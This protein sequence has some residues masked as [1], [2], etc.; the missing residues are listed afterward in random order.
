[1][2][3]KT[4]GQ[5]FTPDWIVNE[6]LN[7]LNYQKDNI[8][9]KKII[10]PACGDGAFLK[11][12]V[13]RIIDYF[14]SKNCSISEIK[15]YIENNVYGIEI[16]EVEFK[17]C[18]TNLNNL[19]KK[20]LNIDLNIDWKIYR[21]NTLLKYKDFLGLFDYV[22]GNPPYI[23]IHS[24]DIETRNLLKKDFVFSEGT[25]DI[26]VSF[27]ELGFKLLNKNG[28]LGYITPNSY[29][30]NSSYKQFRKY[31]KDNKII[32]SITDFKANK[33]FKNFSTYTAITIINFYDK[34]KSFIYKELK[35]DKIQEV[36]EIDY[37]E[38]NDND[39]SFSI[40]EDMIFLK[41][42]YSSTN[43][44]VS[45]F[46]DVQYGFA[47]LRDKI[48]IGKVLKEKDNLV[49]FNN[50]WIEKEIL[51]KIVKGSTYKGTD[52]EMKYIIFPYKKGASRYIAIPEEELQAKYPKA[53][54]YLLD[55]KEELLKRDI[56]KDSSWY[57]FGRSQ[58]I[59]TSHNDKIVLSTLLNH[60]IHFY[61]ADKNTFVYS[62]IFITKKKKE[63]S[64]DII[65]NILNSDDFYKYIQITGK[66]FSGGYKSIT[67]NQI[68][69][70]P[71]TENCKQQT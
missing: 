48:Y 9:N 26:Y 57:E 28:Q 34:N 39:W 10:D 43:K 12:I 67:T 68:K 21:D 51:Y 59:Q 58:G 5:V 56:E 19:I 40:K 64:W 30:H 44:K 63:T 60:E 20:E 23:R 71:T 16:D 37:N 14:L 7:S 35:K 15:N 66:D 70:Y 36:N 22:V 32:Q 65:T 46:F 1:M 69:N 33:I 27:F 18:I 8:L 13:K 4:L 11:I 61:K 31:L 52:K 62:G 38:V 54:K 42:L 3:H 45:D 49:L 25:I 6:I 47:T 55:N 17:N 50:Y 53:Y 24:L 41:K 2:K 29:L